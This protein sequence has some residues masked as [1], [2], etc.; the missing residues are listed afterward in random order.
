VLVPG[1]QGRPEYHRP[2]VDSLSRTFDVMAPPLCGEPG[3]TEREAGGDVDRYASVIAGV[4][5][6][7][8]IERAI[9]CGISFGGIPALRFAATFP[10]RTIAL[11]LAS[12]PGPGWHLRPHHAF[13]ASAPR[14]FGPLFLMES[15]VR[16]FAEL[17]AALPSWTERVRYARWQLWTLVAAPLSVTRMAARAHLMSRLDVV[18]DCRRTTSPTLVVTGEPVLDQIVDV[19]ATREYLRLIDGA[20]HAIVPRTGHLGSVTRPDAFAAIVSE[21]VSRR[22]S[23]PTRASA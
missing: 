13:Y 19:N 3:C 4:L 12:V 15:P 21:F 1:I 7:R 2:A 17:R 22:A 16:L 11:V 9:I 6:R 18:A 23:A 8:R 14:I 20:E 10:Q 5:D